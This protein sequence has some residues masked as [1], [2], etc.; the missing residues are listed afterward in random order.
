MPNPVPNTPRTRARLR[1]TALGALVAATAVAGAS[2]TAAFAD[3]TAT[4]SPGASTGTVAPPPAPAGPVGPPVDDALHAHGTVTS[5]DGDVLVVTGPRGETATV[6]LDDA[7]TV[8]LDRGPGQGEGSADR[9]ALT[10]GQ[11]V[12]ADLAGDGGA[13]QLVVVEPLR[14]DGEV[15]AVDGDRVTLGGPDGRTSVV[16]VS[17]AEVLADGAA[18]DAS[19]IVVGQHVHAEAPA[20]ADVASDGSFTATRVEVGRPVPPTP[21]A[22]APT[23]PAGSPGAPS[24]DGATPAAP[25]GS[26]TPTAGA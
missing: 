8:V 23:P 13:A 1:R 24:T 4:P 26:A 3:G 16:D 14:A 15:T 5:L 2:A 25:T 22:D 7:T 9:S 10:V 6:T 18:A 11:R 17:G 12:H 20:G 19:A 21:P